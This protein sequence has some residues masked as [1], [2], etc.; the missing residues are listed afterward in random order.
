MPEIPDLIY[1][2]K[3][4]DACVVGR[5]ILGAT[6]SQPVVIR[7]VL[8]QPI[9]SALAGKTVQ[10]V[11]LRGPF[12]H[13]LLS[14]DVELIIHLM[15]AGRMQHVRPGERA[16]GYLCL[17]LA[18]DDG[19]ALNVNDSEKMVK[20]YLTSRGRYG[21]IPRFTGQ[22]IDV[23]SPE[24]TEGKFEEIA[25]R[26]RRKQVRVLVNDQTILSAIGNAY[27]D[28]ILFEARIHPKTLV[29]RLRGED[30]RRLQR[31][32]R[33]VLEWGIQEVE[34]AGAPIQK[35]VRNHLR[36]RNRKGEPCPR[37]GATI[38]RE[39]VRGRDVFFCPRCQPP[40]RAHFI[41]WRKDGA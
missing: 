37:C 33:A 1:V 11:R 13:F 18:L 34:R 2:R 30:L 23:L 31:A 39:G 6:V 4:L 7:T 25:A 10:E 29:S 20:I 8:D 36:V 26:H 16:E 19:T 40:T 17:S 21:Q 5:T 32:I 28:E 12:L 35:K 3:Y 15:L 38:R 24:F 27:A 14:G 22:G 41:D 9:S